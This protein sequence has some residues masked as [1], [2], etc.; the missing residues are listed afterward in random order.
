M[1]NAINEPRLRINRTASLSLSTTWQDVVFNGTSS[2][3]INTYGKE[4]VTGNPMVYYDSA[5]NLIRFYE[6]YDKNFNITLYLSTIATLI[7]TRATLQYRF[8]IPNGI[9]AGVDSYFP[10][11]DSNSWADIGE[12]TITALQ[13]NHA[14][15]SIPLYLTNTIRTNGI[16]LQLR[17][18]N[19]LIT[20]GTA[21]LTTAILLI[22]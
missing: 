5:T 12:V 17:L 4:P 3:N 19:S 10:F 13:I 22:Q 14:A 8:V 1:N 11:P 7:S 21:S 20:L 9:S 6:Q 15:E 16:K 18:S 2:Y